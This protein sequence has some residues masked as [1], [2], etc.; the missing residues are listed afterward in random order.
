MVI[1]HDVAIGIQN[2]SR[3]GT[4]L[5][6]SM[7]P[8][9][10]RRHRRRRRKIS[11]TRLFPT[12]TRRSTERSGREPTTATPPF[13]TAA[14]HG[15]IH[16]RRRYLLHNL[17]KTLGKGRRNT[18]R[19]Y[20]GAPDQPACDRGR[21]YKPTTNNKLGRLLTPIDHAQFLPTVELTR[22]PTLIG[23]QLVTTDRTVHLTL[24]I[25]WASKRKSP[26]LAASFCGLK[27]LVE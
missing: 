7:P 22:L 16:H 19:Q 11:T 21:Q 3:S 12:T 26:L 27:G 8:W 24:I 25:P 4:L 18:C 1:R 13:P 9:R 6:P 5:R 10:A 15:D 20:G 14:C 23:N 2:N 17:R